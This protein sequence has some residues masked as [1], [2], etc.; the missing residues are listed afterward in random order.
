MGSLLT[1]PEPALP[2]VCRANELAVLVLLPISIWR[3]VLGEGMEPVGDGVCELRRRP[4][5]PR[6]RVAA[7]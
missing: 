5:R 6:D 7:P 1:L 4:E 2:L 3:V